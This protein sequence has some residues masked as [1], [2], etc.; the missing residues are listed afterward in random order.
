M[1]PDLEVLTPENGRPDAVIEYVWALP[2]GESS[3]VTVVVP[4]LL[5]SRSLL[6]AT[7]R[8]EFSLKLRL[9]R[10]PGVVISNV[11]VL[12]GA[13][14]RSAPKRIACRILVSGGHAASMRAVRYAETLGLEDTRA[15]FFAFDAE[16]AQRMRDEWAERELEVPLEVEEAPYRD[17]GDPLLAHVRGITADPDAVATVI[18]PELIFSG[19]ARTLHNQRALYVKRLLLFEPRVVLSSV[20]YRLD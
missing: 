12:T 18:M 7:R 17:I 5:R 3:F 1:H 4:E 15:I 13:G 6:K 19:L 14:E 16:E 11:P 9:L 10:E 8:I 2:R 20:P